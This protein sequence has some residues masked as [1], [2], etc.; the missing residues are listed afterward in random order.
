MTYIS[1]S[2]TRFDPDEALQFMILTAAVPARC[3]V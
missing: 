2:I 1:S 3:A